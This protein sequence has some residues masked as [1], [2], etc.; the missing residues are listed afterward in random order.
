MLI[1]KSFRGPVKKRPIL[2]FTSKQD[3]EKHLT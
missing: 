3:D 2:L 1:K